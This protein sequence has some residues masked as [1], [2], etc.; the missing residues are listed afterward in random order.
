MSTYTDCHIRVRENLTIQRCPGS[1]CDGITQQRVIFENPENQYYGTFIGNVSA[2][3]M[4]LST[5]TIADATIAGG[6]ISCS[7]LD[8]Q[9]GIVSNA[10]IV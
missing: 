8:M 7:S 10:K 1:P 4:E 9:D 5:A 6:Q 3:Q 2:G